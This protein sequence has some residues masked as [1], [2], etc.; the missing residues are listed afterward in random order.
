MDGG[1][2]PLMPIDEILDIVDREEIF[3]VDHS[4][5]E[6]WPFFKI[7]LTHPKSLKLL[8]ASEQEKEA[9]HLSASLIGYKAGRHIPSID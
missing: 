8:Q 5:A 2:V 4:D 6:G 3:F 7:Q 9:P 1:L